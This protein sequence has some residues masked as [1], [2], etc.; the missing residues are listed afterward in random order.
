M[1]INSSPH[2]AETTRVHLLWENHNSDIE[3][4]PQTI[5]IDLSKCVLLYIMV[6]IDSNKDMYA[7]D[8][9][10]NNQGE[11][12]Q[13]I[14]AGLPVEWYSRRVT[15]FND[16]IVFDHCSRN[17]SDGKSLYRERNDKYIIPYRIYGLMT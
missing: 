4:E 10:M 9:V 11:N 16:E 8:M 7:T 3:F 14:H 17:Y 5:T 1:I 12:D 15:V 13:T 2:V 6:R